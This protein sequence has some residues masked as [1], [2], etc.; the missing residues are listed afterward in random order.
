MNKFDVGPSKNVRVV[1]II[2][3]YER[4]L[5][6][7]KTHSLPWKTRQTLKLLE[8]VNYSTVL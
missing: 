1:I 7:V 5:E 4:C 6:S 8:I 2:I 3:A